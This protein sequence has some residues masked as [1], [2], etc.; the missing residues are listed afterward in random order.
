MSLTKEDMNNYDKIISKL[1]RFTRKFYINE[2]VKGFILFFAVGLFYF[3]LT[4]FLE[5][6]FWLGT[7]SR[8]ILFWLFVL[9]EVSLFGRFIVYPLLKLFNLSR[10]ISEEDAARIIGKHFPTVNDKL[11]N[12]LQLK[13]EGEAVQ[14]DLLTASID[15]K[16]IELK[17]IPFRFAVNFKTN[18]R[19]L[20]YAVIPILIL[21]AIWISGNSSLFS[22]SYSRVLN[23]EMDYEPPAPFSF[24]ILNPELKSRENE[25]FVLLVKT[26]GKLIPENAKIHF[27]GEDYVLENK[28]PG[29]FSYTFEHLQND[30]Q[31]SLSA[32]HISSK[33]YELKV[34]HVPTIEEFKMR[35]HYPKYIGKANKTIKGSGNTIVPEGT[36]IEWKLEAQNTDQITFELPDTIFNFSKKNKSFSLDEVFSKNT[37][38]KIETSNQAVH[39]YDKLSYQIKVIKDKYPEIKVEMKKDTIQ[40]EM[41]YFHGQVSDDYGLSKLQLVFYPVNEEKEKKVRP[42]SISNTSFDEFV[43]AFPDTLKLEKGKSYEMYFEILDNDGV[44]GSKASKSQ[45]FSYRKLTDDEKEDKQL[46]SQKQTLEGMTKSL[47]KMNQSDREWEEINQMQKEKSSLNYNDRKKLEEFLNRQK[48]ENKRM[49]NYSEK[50]KNDLEDFQ[51]KN[52]TDDYKKELQERLER[53]EK[54]LEKN[55]KLLKELEKYRKKISRT[56]MAKKL[57]KMAK[58]RKSGKRSLDELLEL[59]KR[60][61]VQKKAEKISSDLNKLSEKQKHLSQKEK[62][63]T[64]KA[65]EQ[66]N[67]KFEEIQNELEQLQKENKGLQKPMDLDRNKPKEEDIK[68]DQ[69]EAKGKLEK[70]EENSGENESGH[71]E[72]G[73]TKDDQEKQSR[74]SQNTEKMKSGAQKKQQSAAKKMKEMSA[75]MQ[76]MM[77][78]GNANQ[79]AEDVAMLRQILSNLIVFSF[80]QEDL[81]LDFQAMDSENPMFPNKLEYQQTLKENFE[82]VDDSLYAL[83]LRNPLISDEITEKLTDIDFNI[84]KSLELLAQNHLQTGISKQHYVMNGA[85]SLA[86]LL[87]NALQNMQMM[88]Q[89]QSSGQGQGMPKPGEGE[90]KGQGFQLPDIIKEQEKLGEK[91]KEGS[92]KGKQDGGKQEGDKG[93]N[94]KSGKGQKSGNSDGHGGNQGKKSGNGQLPSDEQMSGELFEIYKQQQKLRFQLQDI[95]EQQ[96]LGSRAKN[97]KDQMEQIEQDLLRD[98]FSRHNQEMMMQIQE[99]LIQLKNASY[100]QLQEN[101]RESKTNHKIYKHRSVEQLKKAKEYFNTTEILNRQSLPLRPNYKQIV[102]DYFSRDHD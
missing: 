47:E 78:M 59:T 71:N 57:E 18:I 21:L 27:H 81:M 55:E 45:L 83:A 14:S 28:K 96:N 63:N 22:D 2:L 13:K 85:N 4:V 80:Q 51:K 92:Q 10:G 66:L 54:R 42:I 16:S 8:L 98:G 102:Q 69:S 61:Y 50:M 68:K 23:Y 79:M 26:Q 33:P 7:T 100:E 84:D 39:N 70:A 44:N 72:E 31:F 9:V 38:Y 30:V 75:K 11:L 89:A 93:E 97:L 60:Y 86:N 40:E 20:K 67:K 15:Q 74:D 48:N 90:G 17:P 37:Y 58:Q 87:D 25:N 19:Y 41:L 29:E 94:G 32:N 34:I 99:Q 64:S 5:Y 53:Q 77:Q 36:K 76:S 88:M 49:K 101:K 1:K 12:V 82:H 56:E 6:F 24:R 62:E 43:Y 91:M 95:I 3:L 35:L 52:K 65:Q 73:M 46:Q